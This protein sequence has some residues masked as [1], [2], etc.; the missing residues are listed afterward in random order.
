[1]FRLLACIF[2]LINASFAPAQF[3]GVNIR[4]LNPPVS[5]V[6][7]ANNGC[8][9]ENNATTSLACTTTNVLLAGQTVLLTITDFNYAGATP[10]ITDSNTGTISHLLGPTI[11][12]SGTGIADIW[13][14][15]NAGAGTHTIT[16]TYNNTASY[17]TE[18]VVVFSGASTTSPVDA[19]TASDVAGGTASCASVTTTSPA[20]MLVSFAAISGDTL[21]AG[22]SP[23][24][25][26]A[27]NIATL[28][29]YGTGRF[30]GTNYVQWTG[31]VTDDFACD[32][33]ALH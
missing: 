7:Y 13:L 16:A 28:V 19:A 6:S 1:M 18:V 11:F 33:I 27:T 9:I 31:S 4:G 5:N 23:Q 25:M 26:T 24:L 3:A 12:H 8:T 29:A 20:D 10:T 21:T 17:A 15:K 32:T 2:L 22:T 14:I 30:V